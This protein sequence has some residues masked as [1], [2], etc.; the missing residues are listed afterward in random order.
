MT[1]IFGINLIFVNG[2][3]EETNVGITTLGTP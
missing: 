1:N 2:T 3:K